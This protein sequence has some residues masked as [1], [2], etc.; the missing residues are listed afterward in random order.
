MTATRNNDGSTAE[1]GL[2]LV[3]ELGQSEGELALAAAD[4]LAASVGGRSAS[5]PWRR[6]ATQDSSQRVFSGLAGQ[7]MTGLK[8][9]RAPANLAQALRAISRPDLVIPCCLAPQQSPTPFHQAS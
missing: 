2:Y 4:P 9:Q 6:P 5:W 3:F 8:R 1:R 7:E